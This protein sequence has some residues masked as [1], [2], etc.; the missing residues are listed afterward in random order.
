MG[1]IYALIAKYHCI[2]WNS[3]VLQRQR[4]LFRPYMTQ[5]KKN[6]YENVRTCYSTWHNYLDPRWGVPL[7]QMLVVSSSTNVALLSERKWFPGRCAGLSHSR[8]PFATCWTTTAAVC[9]WLGAHAHTD[10]PPPWSSQIANSPLPTPG[11]GGGRTGFG[12]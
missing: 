6:H 3:D 2:P 11:R 7:N 9:G 4:C 1:L 12:S 10:H 5:I 8:L